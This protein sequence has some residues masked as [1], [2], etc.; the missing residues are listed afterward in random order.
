MKV[1]CPASGTE[2][3]NRTECKQCGTDLRPLIQL[4]E[5]PDV[6]TAE[7]TVSLAEGRYIDA[8]ESLSTSV[9][10]CP[11]SADAHWRLGEAFAGL[12]QFNVALSHIDR[13]L[14]IAPERD[15]IQR[16]RQAV[17]IS[18]DARKVIEIK[19]APRRFSALSLISSAGAA[20]LLG[21]LLAI[22]GQQLLH[23][24]QP[25]QDLSQTVARRLAADPAT[26]SLNLKVTAHNGSLQIAGQVPSDIYR[27]LIL[28]ICCHDAGIQIDSSQLQVTSPPPP[29]SYQVR[30]GDSW[31]KIARREYGAALVW[32]QIQKA[33]QHQASAPAHLRT[34]DTVVLPSVILVPR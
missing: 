34:G 15:E 13:A 24:T 29:P 33:N 11:D 32:P 4:A 20:C 21:L 6:L 3:E 1:V 26:R 12:G 30:R 7:G 18:A 27:Q 23:R 17:A 22:A 28:Q 9:S 2:N 19:K 8:V 31:W 16:V 25:P 14:Q 5:F 10:L